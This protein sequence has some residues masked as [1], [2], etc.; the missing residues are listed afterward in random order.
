MLFQAGDFVRVSTA[1]SSNPHKNHL[2]GKIF[3]VKGESVFVQ[4]KGDEGVVYLLEGDPHFFFAN[5]LEMV[6]FPKEAFENGMIVEYRD[7][8]LR[9]VHNGLLIGDIKFNNLDVYDNELKST[10]SENQDIIR[11]Y[12]ST[13]CSFTEMWK[14][15]TRELIW[16]RN[17]IEPENVSLDDLEKLLGYRVT[18]I[19]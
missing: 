19:D 8:S 11:I 5:E 18:V 2:V 17:R 16:T 10:E 15:H 1:V 7:G 3:K 13:A 14:E 12:K 9:M 4:K 6:A